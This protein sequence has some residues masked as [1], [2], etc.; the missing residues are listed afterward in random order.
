MT[1][2][3]PHSNQAFAQTNGIEI[4]YDTFGDPSAPPLLLI[5]GLGGQLINW[6]EEFC[7]QLATRGYWVI[8]FDNRDVGL[9][10]KFDEA[11]V[12]DIP[13]LTEA[14]ERGEKVQMELS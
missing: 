6:H 11:G 12:P 8:R 2:K 4:A 7:A 14:Q 3:V 13:Q 9:S 5:M 10:T 1:Q